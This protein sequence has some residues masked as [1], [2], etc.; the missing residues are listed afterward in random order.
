MADDKKA[1][2]GADAEQKPAAQAAGKGAKPKKRGKFGFYMV[3]ILM[4]IMAPF[5]LPTLALIMAGMLPT[6]VAI[7][8]DQDREKSSTAAIGAMNCAGL[9]PFIIDL[10]VS[11]QSMDNVVRLLSESSTWLVMLGAAGIGQLIVFAVP[12]ALATLT[13]ARAETRLKTLKANL[14]QL[15][16]VWGPDVA[17]T[18]PIEKIITSQN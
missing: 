7:F 5:I 3:M 1:E 12:Q 15:K 17:T 4:G 8:V 11:G 2:G 13:L 10:W 16:T 9:T 18:R 6:V 14:E